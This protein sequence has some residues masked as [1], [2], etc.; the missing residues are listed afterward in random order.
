MPRRRAHRRTV[1]ALA[2]AL[3]L[4]LAAVARLARAADEIGVAEATLA[5]AAPGAIEVKATASL[6]VLSLPVAPGVP[7]KKGALLAAVDVTKLELELAATRQRL[8]SLQS[9]K[10]RMISS[11]EVVRGGTNP[12]ASTTSGAADRM[13]E[14]VTAEADTARDLLDV[15]TRLATASI[16]A[17][18]DGYVV[19][20]LYAVGAKAKRRKPFLI[21]APVE[22]TRLTLSLKA[23][24]AAALGVGSEALVVSAADPTARFR[25]R[26][27]GAAPGDEGRVA[28]VLRPLELPFVALG[29]ASTV[30]IAPAP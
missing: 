19:K 30:R 10:R 16:R 23:S 12:N 9:E 29:V 3:G 27:E 1:R 20:T 5:V 22:R 26:V 6:P 4:H 15:Q 25:A 24:E 2:A 14:I 11:Q 7:V 13:M 17:P 18:E 28:L 8:Q 21:F